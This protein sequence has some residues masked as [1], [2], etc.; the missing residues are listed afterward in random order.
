MENFNEQL[1]ILFKYTGSPIPR[2]VKFKID[3]SR[4]TISFPLHAPEGIVQIWCEGTSQRLLY[5]WALPFFIPSM[6]G[7]DECLIFRGLTWGNMIQEKTWSKKSRVT[8]PLIIS[9]WRNPNLVCEGTSQSPYKW[10]IHSLFT[11]WLVVA[12]PGCLS[13]IQIFTHSGSRI[14]DHGSKNSNKREGWK[15]L[16]SNLFL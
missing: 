11:P 1:Y 16:L 15:N 7:G 8:V 13:R 4:T 12:D 14:W 5:K 3:S 6:V 10:A 2:M 9:S